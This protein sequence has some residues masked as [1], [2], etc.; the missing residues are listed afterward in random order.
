MAFVGDYICDNC[1]ETFNGV[2]SIR[3]RNLCFKCQHIETEREILDVM[4]ESGCDRKMAIYLLK[5]KNKINK[6]PTV[7]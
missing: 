6:S 4:Q 7:Y 2:H 1:Y 3:S 5:L